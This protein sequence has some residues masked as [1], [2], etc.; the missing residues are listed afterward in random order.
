MIQNKL[1]VS[2]AEMA[3]LLS[4]SKPTAYQIIRRADF[5]GAF[6]VGTKTL[7]SVA[8]IQKW[9]DKQTEADG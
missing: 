5:T 8:G 7:V 6:K 4:I 1:A 2:V 3:D 9:I